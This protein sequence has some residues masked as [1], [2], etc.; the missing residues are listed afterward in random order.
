MQPERR[1]RAEA[2][3]VA[4]AAPLPVF[5]FSF[6]LPRRIPS[7]AAFILKAFCPLRCPCRCGLKFCGAGGCT[8]GIE[9]QR[10]NPLLWG[11]W[12]VLPAWG[13]PPAPAS[14]RRG[15]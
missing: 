6:P 12:P 14:T 4:L 1:R 10:F 2:G 8:R 7:I 5:S 15:E 3:G 9:R 11:S 13:H